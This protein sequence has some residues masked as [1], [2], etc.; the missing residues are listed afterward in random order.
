MSGDRHSPDAVQMNRKQEYYII[1][2]I[3]HY[4]TKSTALQN[5]Q[6]K[7]NFYSYRKKNGISVLIMG[8]NVSTQNASSSRLHLHNYQ[9]QPNSSKMH[10][11]HSVRVQSVEI[12]HKYGFLVW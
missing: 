12:Y 2:R 3:L 1:A 10:H 11:H 6:P 8:K 5:V 7:T 9:W 4:S